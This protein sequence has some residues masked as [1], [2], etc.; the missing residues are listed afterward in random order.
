M[1]NHALQELNTNGERL[2]LNPQP[3]HYGSNALIIVPSCPTRTQHKWGE[4]GFEPTT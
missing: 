4:V 3:Y 1:P 2:D